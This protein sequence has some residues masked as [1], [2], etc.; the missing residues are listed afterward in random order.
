M[1][2]RQ[3]A[4]QAYAAQYERD[5]GRIVVPLRQDIERER[6]AVAAA[7]AAGHEKD[8]ERRE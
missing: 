7:E 8:A 2:R 3:K 6:T 1:P 4:A 5:Q